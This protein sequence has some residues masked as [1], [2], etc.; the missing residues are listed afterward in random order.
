MS[1]LFP[2]A[3]SPIPVIDI[4]H[5]D[6][7]TASYLV[8]AAANYGFVF[9]KGELGFTPEVVNDAFALVS[10]HIS[11]RKADFSPL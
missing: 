5:E 8:E 9:V 2:S 6:E 3:E 1:P 10:S 11:I 4:S 7:E